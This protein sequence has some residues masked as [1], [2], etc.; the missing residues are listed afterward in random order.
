M[1]KFLNC[2]FDGHASVCTIHYRISIY[3]IIHFDFQLKPILFILESK[4]KEKILKKIAFCCLN[5][6]F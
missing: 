2:L 3:M 4:L 5:R 1:S 6:F